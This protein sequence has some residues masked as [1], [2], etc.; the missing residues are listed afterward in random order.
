MIERNRFVDEISSMK[1]EDVMK[2][3]RENEMKEILRIKFF[4]AKPL[5]P[6]R[7]SVAWRLGM[8]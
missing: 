6:F 2:L 3:N 7:S 5:D 1:I 8:A 4:T